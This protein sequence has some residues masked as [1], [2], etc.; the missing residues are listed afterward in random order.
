M[1]PLQAWMLVLLLLGSGLV[2]TMGDAMSRQH[3]ECF[4]LG[5]GLRMLAVVVAL[6]STASL[7]QGLRP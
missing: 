1:T 6:A 4:W 3:S 5:L 2:F 7:W